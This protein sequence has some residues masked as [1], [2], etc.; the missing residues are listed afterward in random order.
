MGGLV[1]VLRVAMPPRKRPEELLCLFGTKDPG[2]RTA[3]TK[4]HAKGDFGGRRRWM[5]LD[6][7]VDGTVGVSTH[8]SVTRVAAYC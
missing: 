1:V 6:E 3:L 2:R 4:C 8:E 7:I 5:S